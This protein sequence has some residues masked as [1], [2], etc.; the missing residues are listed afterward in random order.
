MSGASSVI[1]PSRE[2]RLSA[3]AMA[4]SERDLGS[5]ARPF[6]R[7]LDGMENMPGAERGLGPALGEP[8]ELRDRAQA[9]GGRAI[10]STAVVVVG[11]GAGAEPPSPLKDGPCISASARRKLRKA[12]DRGAHAWAEA[13]ILEDVLGGDRRP[14]DVVSVSAGPSPSWVNRSPHS[15]VPVLS[16][17]RTPASQPWGVCGVSR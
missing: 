12:A 14:D 7:T 9:C 8:D 5:D 16:S 13:G 11:Q 17:N 2:C 3:L 4:K 10:E 15:S 6:D 1:G